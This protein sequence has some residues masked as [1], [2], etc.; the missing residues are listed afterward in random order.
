A[1]LRGSAGREAMAYLERRGVDRATA[2]R[3]EL[4]YAPND[5]QGLRQA[6]R[7]Q[8]FGDA[9]LIAAGLIKESDGREPYAHFRH[10]LMFPIADERGRLVG[11]GGRALGEV[12][13]KYLNTPET[14]LFHK[15][16]LLYNLTRA[17]GPARE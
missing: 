5:G 8:G 1:Q 7:S 15:G 2:A 16:E 4:G 6:L 9:E 12:R 13:A 10:R 14:V 17:K 11:F 3:F